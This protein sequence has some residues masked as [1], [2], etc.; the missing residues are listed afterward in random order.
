[1][2]DDDLKAER[3]LLRTLAAC[4]SEARRLAALLSVKSCQEARALE[5]VVSCIRPRH[6][7]TCMHADTLSAKFASSVTHD[8]G[9]Q[10]AA[11]C[12][13]CTSHTCRD[14]LQSYSAGIQSFVHLQTDS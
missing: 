2:Q 5:A 3:P 1:M 7:L 14:V 10:A 9:L 4:D 12:K 11:R 8:G 13:G 6:R